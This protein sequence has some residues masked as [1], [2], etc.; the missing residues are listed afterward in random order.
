MFLDELKDILLPMGMYVDNRER[1][2][3]DITWDGKSYWDKSHYEEI[4]ND[5]MNCRFIEKELKE[6]F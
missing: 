5:L 6:D 3:G 2:F 1:H 4:W